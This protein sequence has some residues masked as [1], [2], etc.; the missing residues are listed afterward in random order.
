MSKTLNRALFMFILLLSFVLVFSGCSLW[1]LNEQKV[2]NQKAAYI[3]DISVTYDDVYKAYYNYGNYYF[4][5][6][7]TPTYKGMEQTATQLVNREVLVKALKDKEGKYHTTLSQKEIN[8]VWNNLYDSLNSSLY[9]YQKSI[10]E[11]DD[12]TITELKNEDE[13]KTYDNNYEKPYES[14]NK[15]YE[16]EYV[17]DETTQTSSYKLTKIQE[18]EEVV[19]SSNDVFKF[20]AEEMEG[21]DSLETKLASMTEEAKATRVY[22]NFKTFFWN[23]RN[24]QD[25]NSKGEFYKDLAFNKLISVLKSNEKDKSLNM[26]AKFVLYRYFNETFDSLYDSALISAFQNKFEKTQSISEELVL[27][28]FKNLSEAQAEKYRNPYDDYSSFV[29]AMKSRTEPML[30]FEKTNEWFQVSH[31]LLKYSD[32]DVQKLKTLQNELKDGKIVKDTYDKKVLEIKNAMKFV[33]RKDG[34]TYSA[35]EVLSMLY[36][37]MGITVDALGNATYSSQKTAQDR[38]EAFNDFIYRFNM[39]D[40][41]NNASLAYY[42]PKDSKYD[43]MVTPFANASRTLQQSGIVGSISDLIEIDETVGYKDNNGETQTPSYSGMH[44]VVYLGEINSLKTNGTATLQDLNS[45][46]LN[47]LNNNST[48]QKTMLDYVIEKINIDNFTA[49]QSSVLSELKGT[50]EI[51]TNKQVLL[52]LVK[53]FSK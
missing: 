46:V 53:A 6:Q 45:Y 25:K 13:E 24:D 26:D 17:W 49:Y 9:D 48:N 23:H 10:M 36:S 35:K 15:T 3:D 16:L 2:L 51:Y 32:S 44:I 50:K 7:G 52:D 11:K 22:N 1:T 34:K 40:G 28:T 31:I 33:D 27:T 37:A 18:N 19:T 38:L 30:Y 43:G 47:P 20:T 39:D 21:F 4:D 29:S 5:G 12:K 14:Y 42:I 8:D 41:V